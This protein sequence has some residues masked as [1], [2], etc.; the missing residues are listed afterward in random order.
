MAAYPVQSAPRLLWDDHLHAREFFSWVHRPV[1]GPGP[2]PGV[3]FRVAGGGSEVRG[4]APLLGE[5]NEYVFR[6]LLG[7]AEAEYADLVAR[8]IIA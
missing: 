7:I 1:V 8:E 5:H 3:T 2:I 6:E 4:Y